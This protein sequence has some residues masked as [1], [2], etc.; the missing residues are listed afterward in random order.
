M[1]CKDNLFNL[2]TVNITNAEIFDDL[3]DTLSIATAPIDE[4]NDIINHNSN[5]I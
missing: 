3:E 2:D 4:T 1:D 5:S